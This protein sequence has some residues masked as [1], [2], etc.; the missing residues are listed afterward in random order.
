MTVYRNQQMSTE[1]ALE[2]LKFVDAS[3]AGQPQ[4]AELFDDIERQVNDPL[5][6]EAH[7]AQAR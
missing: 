6:Y 7:Y 4:L 5:E 1:L 2:L 3:R